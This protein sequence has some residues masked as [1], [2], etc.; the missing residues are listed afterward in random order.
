MR[1]RHE[2]IVKRV[3]SNI[4]E[5]KTVATSITLR[6]TPEAQR[7]CENC[8]HGETAHGFTGTRPCLAS[9]GSL[10]DPDFCKCDEFRPKIA[11]AA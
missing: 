6:T 3:A 9:V 7:V 5:N 4:A 8:G 11:K 2:T 10:F 1:V